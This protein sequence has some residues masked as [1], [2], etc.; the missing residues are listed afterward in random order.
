MLNQF[1]FGLKTFKRYFLSFRVNSSHKLFLAKLIIRSWSERLQK[2]WAMLWIKII[3]EPA[4]ANFAV[5]HYCLH[6]VRSGA[7]KIYS[8]KLRLQR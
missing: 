4:I 6:R 2:G 3:I 8:D 7:M 5:A 1:N